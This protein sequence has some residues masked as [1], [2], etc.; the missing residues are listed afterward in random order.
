M[1]DGCAIPVNTS[2]HCGL[3]ALDGDAARR[4]YFAAQTEAVLDRT[5]LRRPRRAGRVRE[6]VGPAASS[7]ERFRTDSRAVLRHGR[8]EH[9]RLEELAIGLR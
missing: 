9:V 5:G 7:P 4:H 3:Y 2:C 1:G 6:R 8:T